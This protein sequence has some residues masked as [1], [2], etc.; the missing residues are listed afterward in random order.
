VLSPVFKTIESARSSYNPVTA[1][2]ELLTAWAELVASVSSGATNYSSL[3]KAT[4]SNI[5]KLELAYRITDRKEGICLEESVKDLFDSSFDPKESSKLVKFLLENGYKKVSDLAKIPLAEFDAE[6]PE[7]TAK[8]K[9]MI[10]YMLF[11]Q[12]DVVLPSPHGIKPRELAEITFPTVY[13]TE[14]I[15]QTQ[16]E[17]LEKYL[18]RSL[19]NTFID[20]ASRFPRPFSLLVNP[21]FLRELLNNDIISLADFFA[22]HPRKLDVITQNAFP[23]DIQRAKTTFNAAQHLSRC[24]REH[25]LIHK[26]EEL[27]EKAEQAKEKLAKK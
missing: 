9:L 7:L 26:E 10:R 21:K 27:R 1:R 11:K 15:L 8:Q 14:P 18:A 12:Y 22:M 17:G 20:L 24:V 3:H 6:F 4:L 25:Y 23:K 19:F 2:K 5:E 16:K 13:T